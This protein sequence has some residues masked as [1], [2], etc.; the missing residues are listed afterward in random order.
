MKTSAIFSLIALTLTINLNASNPSQEFIV[1]LNSSYEENIE[2]AD[3]M[4]DINEFSAET[5]MIEIEE[6][7]TAFDQTL[8]S[9]IPIEDWMLN[10]TLFTDNE[11]LVQ[12][13][14]WMLNE[15]LFTDYERNLALKEWMFNVQAFT[16]DTNDETETIKIEDWMIDFDNFYASF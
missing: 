15:A 8:E 14:A 4:L 3:W 16:G 1:S 10:E 7:M 12:L 9:F 13:E 11:E 6:W 5:E 2:V